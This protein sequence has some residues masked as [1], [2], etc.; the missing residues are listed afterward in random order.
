MLESIPGK[1]FVIGVSILI[2][3]IA[4][5]SQLILFLPA[6]GGWNL[7]S[8]IR[9][10]PLNALVMMVFYNYYLAVVTDPGKIPTGWEPPSSLVIFKEIPS[11][12]ITG[13]R[14]CK[15]CQV[16]KPPRSHHC[17]Y[18]RRCV[19]KMDHHCPWINNCVGHANYGHFMRFII[20]ADLACLYVILLLVGRV[21]AIMD[22]IRHFQFDAEPTTI[23][24]IFM[25]LNFVFAF[26]VLFCVGILTG[27]QLYCLSKNQTNIEAW[28]RG[29]V[30]DLIRRGKI[31]PVNYPFDVG[32]YR[33]IREVLGSNPLL[34]LWPQ[35]MQGDGLTFPMT[36]ETDPRLP[37]YWPPRDPDDLRPSI[38]SS[39]YKR[40]Q[41]IQR[42]LKEDPDAARALEEESEGYYDSGSFISDSEAEYSIDD[43]EEGMKRLMNQRLYDLSGTYFEHTSTLMGKHYNN[44]NNNRDALLFDKDEDEDEDDSSNDDTISLSTFAFRKKSYPS[45]KED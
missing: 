3:F 42:L 16:Y 6:Y 29:K 18:C 9:L 41:E 43:E 37:Y 25:V 11:E 31:S 44:N 12:G 39:K 19:L 35:K 32:F 45:T 1:I 30:E 5:S 13:P 24:I 26:I 34:W 33:N 27:Y 36:P 22:A 17:R 14:Y 2:S 40:Q 10:L 8:L 7:K 28:E 15:S 20:F 4:Y 23:E 38:F 21:R